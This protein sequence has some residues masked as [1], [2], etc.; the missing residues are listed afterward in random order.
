MKGMVVTA[1]ESYASGDTDFTTLL[2]K[3][4]ATEPDA[5]F[6]PD[7]YGKVS[8]IL[9]QAR[10]AG[11]DGPMLGGDGWDGVL[12]TLPADKL[13]VANNGYFSNHYSAT[14]TDPVVVNFLEGYKELFDIDANAFAAL[15]YDSAYILK[16]AIEAAGSTEAAA[17]ID[18][19]ADTEY[20]G[21]T[22]HI[23]FDA[24]GDPI[25]S[26]AI[27][28]FVDGTAQLATKITA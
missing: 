24:N 18:A 10:S 6:V 27:T 23:T 17:I 15:G 20:D 12:S 19:L 22:G 11:F 14:D 16:N 7:Y 5:I 28:Q 9:D 13:S 4:I 1:F 2:N 8:L 26:V 25:K 21:V 3:I